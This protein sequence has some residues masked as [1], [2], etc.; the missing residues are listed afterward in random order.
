MGM[1][2]A[3][4]AAAAAASSEPAASC[5]YAFSWPSYKLF[6]VS[7]PRT[8]AEIA[9]NANNTIATL[10]VMGTC[11]CEAEKTVS[12][13]FQASTE[14]GK[15]PDLKCSS[16]TSTACG[17]ETN[18]QVVEMWCGAGKAGLM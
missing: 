11:V 10:P 3:P 15:E 2:A 1:G 8:A 4:A 12:C 16:S 17:T 18:K 14:A 13:S 7:M 5:S 6:G 9:A